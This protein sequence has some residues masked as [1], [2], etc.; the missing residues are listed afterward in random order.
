MIHV[1]NSELQHAGSVL[2]NVCVPVNHPRVLLTRRLRL[3]KSEARPEML[4]FCAKAR[5]RLWSR[6]TPGMARSPLSRCLVPGAW[7]GKTRGPC[8]ARV[9]PGQDPTASP[10][11]HCVPHTPKSQLYPRSP[12]LFHLPVLTPVAPNMSSLSRRL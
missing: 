2:L 4:R 1:I 12:A 9:L 3:R 5:R 11:P 8:V 10:P 7:D 6:I